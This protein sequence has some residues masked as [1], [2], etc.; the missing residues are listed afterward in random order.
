MGKVCREVA[1]QDGTLR[2]ASTY[3][4]AA[5]DGACRVVGSRRVHARAAIEAS[6]TKAG[7]RVLKGRC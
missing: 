1:E 3:R 5:R 4:Q 6:L 7:A 2:H